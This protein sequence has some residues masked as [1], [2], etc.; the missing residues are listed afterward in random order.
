M[1]SITKPLDFRLPECALNKHKIKIHFLSFLMETVT[2]FVTQWK[3]REIVG[4]M[5]TTGIW[6]FTTI[7]IKL[8]LSGFG[9]GTLNKVA[10]VILCMLFIMIS[11]KKE[12]YFNQYLVNMC[13]CT[14]TWYCHTYLMCWGNWL[15]PWLFI[16]IV[17]L[18]VNQNTLS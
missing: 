8:Y 1:C 6:K 7:S 4:I 17:I 12:A 3:E 16:L 11:K 5:T 13:T 18:H 2:L 9:N 14:F 15:F 10:F